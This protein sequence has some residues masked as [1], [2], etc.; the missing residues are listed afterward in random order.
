MG[1]Q[2]QF[3]YT[4]LL[5]QNYITILIIHSQAKNHRVWSRIYIIYICNDNFSLQWIQ[6]SVPQSNQQHH[7]HHIHINTYIR[8]LTHTKRDKEREE[9]ETFQRH[10]RT[11]I[12]IWL[13]NFALHFT[14]TSTNTS[15]VVPNA[16][17][18]YYIIHEKN[19]IPKTVFGWISPSAAIVHWNEYTICTCCL[20]YNIILMAIYR[21]VYKRVYALYIV[22][23]L[24]WIYAKII[25]L[26][27]SFL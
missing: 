24:F 5:L 16:L 9:R 25:I 22:A 10:N 8:R 3:N 7:G 21:T 27:I 17:C 11:H 4:G 19:L 12:S 2:Y 18:I 26:R 6:V 15:P 20:W 23:W 14:S 13:A 1:L